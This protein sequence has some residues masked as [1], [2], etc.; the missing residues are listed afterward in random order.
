[1]M[2]INPRQ[3]ES[4]L[5]EP[6]MTYRSNTELDDLD[7][8]TTRTICDAIGERLQ[9]AMR[10]ETGPSPRLQQLMNEFRQRDFSSRS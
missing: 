8:K 6:N 7:Y 1:M 4:E 9:Q 2:P 5:G 10:P 3:L